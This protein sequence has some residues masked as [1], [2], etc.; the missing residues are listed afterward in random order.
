VRQ[1][2]D[3]RESTNLSEQREARIAWTALENDM[4][5]PR[6]APNNPCTF[7][8][9]QLRDIDNTEYAVDHMVELWRHWNLGTDG[10]GAGHNGADLPRW[11]LSRLDQLRYI[12]AE[13]NNGRNIE[14]KRQGDRIKYN[15]FVGP[16]F[17]SVHAEGF[18]DNARTILGEPF[19]DA[20]NGRSIG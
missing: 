15:P 5:V 16:N 3:K 12:T 6:K 14:A 1:V 8:N 9:V 13:D 11:S 17:K 4:Q 10:G 7:N 2:V 19:L 20:P 18:I